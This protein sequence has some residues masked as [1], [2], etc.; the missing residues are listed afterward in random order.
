MKTQAYRS[1]RHT[2]TS[3]SAS[4][5]QCSLTW[6]WPKR[7][8]ENIDNSQ[9]TAP[10]TECGTGSTGTQIS[11]AQVVSQSALGLHFDPERKVC[12][13]GDNGMKLWREWNPQLWQL[14]PQCS[15]A[16]GWICI[17]LSGRKGEIGKEQKRE[18]H[19]TVCVIETAKVKERFGKEVHEWVCGCMS[20]TERDRERGELGFTPPEHGGLGVTLDYSIF[21]HTPS[22]GCTDHGW[23]FI[24][25]Q[26]GW[27][28]FDKTQTLV[29]LG[30]T[31]F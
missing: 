22:K 30:L 12:H 27:S 16:V 13:V 17:C 1:V 5:D 14:C 29:L 7:K 9:F 3:V 25:D 4:I 18:R 28:D 23:F 21:S 2:I 10:H 19:A 11:A 26:R 24:C 15:G 8:K 31:N 20:E 6:W